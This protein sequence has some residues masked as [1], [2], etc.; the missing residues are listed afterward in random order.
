MAE[1]NPFSDDA[2]ARPT[3][4]TVQSALD[5]GRKA[6]LKLLESPFGARHGRPYFITKDAL[7][8]EVAVFVTEE[9]ALLPHPIDK[10][11]VAE[12]YNLDSFLSYWK[13]HSIPV[14]RI[15]AEM[16]P[17]VRFTGVI[18]EHDPDGD[19]GWRDHRVVYEPTYSREWKTWSEQDRK[20][21]SN[22]EELAYWIEDRLPDIVNPPAEDF[23]SMITTFRVDESRYWNNEVKLSNG[24][25][26][27]S[28]KK[29]VDGS[30]QDA[31]GGRIA[32]P[33]KFQLNIPVFSGLGAP[34]Y[35]VEARFRWRSREGRI[36]FKYE[37]VRPHKV[38][39]K[40]FSEL[41]EQ[42]QREAGSGLLFGDPNRK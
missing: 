18:D 2:S 7:G 32:V 11:G 28:Y 21:F 6:A 27:F 20:D 15:Y 40:A 35:E 25:V 16:I 1:R 4:N 38:V 29:M 37:L 36:S 13:E 33:E 19:P 34:L 26:D 14:S 9:E 17:Q 31:S 12:M 30:A 24:K 5:A 10:S 23:L 42:V 39:E 8:R 3:G 41:L 22:N